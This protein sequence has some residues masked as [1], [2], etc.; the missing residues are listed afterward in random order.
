[1]IGATG[2]RHGELVGTPALARVRRHVAAE[3]EARETEPAIPAVRIAEDWHGFAHTRGKRAVIVGG[4][5][6]EERQ[7]M[8]QQAFKFAELDWPD[9]PKNSP[10]RSGAVISQAKRGKYDFVICLQRFISHN[11]TDALFD[12]EV[13]GTLVVLSEGYGVQ[14]LRAGFDRYLPRPTQAERDA[15]GRSAIAPA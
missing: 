1:M 2:G 5:G 11:I 7:P 4:D 8:L 9:V 13:P 14:Q 10:G 12:L 3:L 15:N 6:R